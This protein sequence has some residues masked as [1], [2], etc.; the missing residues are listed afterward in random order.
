[1]CFLNTRKTIF[2][3]LGSLVVCSFVFVVT[4]I[5]YIHFIQKPLRNLALQ[6]LSRAQK[7]PFYNSHTRLIGTLPKGE[8]PSSYLRQ[9]PN[10]R[11]IRIG[12][13]GDSHTWG[14]E[15]ASGN[16]YPSQLQR[17]LGDRYQVIL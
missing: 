13:F 15:T 4:L 14:T 10:P 7:N 17:L 1:M 8:N 3:L 16:D 9:K 2:I 11:K 5:T 12:C 6:S